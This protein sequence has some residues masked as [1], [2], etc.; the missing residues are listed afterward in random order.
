MSISQFRRSIEKRFPGCTLVDNGCELCLEAPAK[1]TWDGDLHE[2]VAGY[3]AGLM[4]SRSAKDIA[5]AIADL[6]ARVEQPQPC[7]VTDCEWCNPDGE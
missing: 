4:W 6:K 3:R 2:F 7:T 5:S 1:H